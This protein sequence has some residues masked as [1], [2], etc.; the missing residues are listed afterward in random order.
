MKL[1]ALAGR[2]WQIVREHRFLIVLGALPSAAF[3]LLQ[4]IN[5][6]SGG[7]LGT[8]LGFVITVLSQGALVSGVGHITAGERSSFWRAMGT[9]W[10]RKWDLFRLNLFIVIPVILLG[11][12]FGL[13]LAVTWM[14]VLALI[15]QYGDPE[16][17][18]TTAATSF[19]ISAL[20]VLILLLCAI[21]LALMQNFTDDACLLE[22][23]SVLASYQRAA[24]IVRDHFGAAV[25]LTALQLLLAL[26]ADIVLFLPNVVLTLCPL[27]WP[28][29]WILNGALAAFFNTL[30]TLV[31]Q[32][33]TAAR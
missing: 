30:Y 31:W 19:G 9:A 27:G 4:L 23:L 7:I 11:V 10:D 14:P 33:W 22:N 12:I 32:E 6:S 28:L 2:S 15:S 17:I 3:W 1:F 24:R 16:T 21:P 20:L 25:G 13:G 26:A 29:Q 18:R 8:V 5:L